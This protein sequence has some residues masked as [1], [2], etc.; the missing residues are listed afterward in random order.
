MSGPKV[1]NIEALRRRQ[2]R[3]TAALLNTVQTLFADCLRLCGEDME[4]Q[5]ALEKSLRVAIARTTA[6]GEAD[7]WA[8]AIAELRAREEFLRSEQTHLRDRMTARHAERMRLTHRQ[9]TAASQAKKLIRALPE[10]ERAPLSQRLDAATEDPAAIDAILQELSE[11]AILRDDSENRERLIKLV[12]EFQPAAAVEK[13]A[14]APDPDLARL[15]RCWKLLGEWETFSSCDPALLEDWKKAA[16]S[17]SQAAPAER[18]LRLDSL[19]LELSTHLRNE[20]E[21]DSLIA[22]LEALA[23][24]FQSLSSDASSAFQE[25]IRLARAR[26]TELAALRSILTEARA[27]LAG[28][29]AKSDAIAQRAAI[30]RGLAACGY[31]VRQGM[32]TAWVEDGHVVLQKP[33]EAGYGV[34]FTAPASGTSIQT[35]VVALAASGRDPRRDKEMEDNWCGDFQKLRKLLESEGFSAEIRHAT[36]AGSTAMKAAATLSDGQ[37]RILT[38]TKQKLRFLE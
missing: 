10:S 16:S 5:D 1:V 36:P 17:A 23:I 35:R 20:R 7:K 37:S 33:G 32:E 24:E 15:E 21:R 11:K 19:I 8:E 30:L 27:H 28:E 26:P 18:P 4:K 22:E 6:L 14:A 38:E 29:L 34:E 31:E 3:E 13:I 25:K 12:A 2:K 9:Q